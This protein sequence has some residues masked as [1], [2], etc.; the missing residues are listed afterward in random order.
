M[1]DRVCAVIVTYN[2]KE[3]LRE[4]LQA[5]LS[6]TRPVDHILAV[7]N[8]STDGTAEM[9]REE[10]PQVEVLRLPENQGSAGGFHEGMK[11]A[12][13]LDYD[14]LWLMDDDGIPEADTLGKLIENEPHLEFKGCLVLSKESK[15]LTAFDYLLPS[16]AISRDVKEI[17]RAYPEGRLIGFLNPYS[18]CL[19]HRS[20]ISK[21]GLPRKELFIWGDEVEYFLRA[22]HKGIVVGTVLSAAFYHPEDRQLRI[23][24]KLW[25]WHISLPYSK[26]QKRFYLI[27]RNQTYNY[28]V[29]ISRWKIAVK[30]FL[31]ALLFPRRFPILLRALGDAVLLS[32]K[33]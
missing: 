7:D 17:L 10:F 26:E 31:Y 23:G 6:Q 8:A 12:Y 30:I 11:R 16:G 19:V 4:C 2:R 33:R 32:R 1:G 24:F 22:K 25:V 15:A 3:L 5:V 21:I 29:Y 14:W 13:E 9:L 27:I 18:G 28:W 20:V